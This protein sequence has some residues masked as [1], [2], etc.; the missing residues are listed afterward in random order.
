MAEV[1]DSLGRFIQGQNIANLTL[2]EIKGLLSEGL[3]KP[4]GAAKPVGKNQTVDPSIS[5]LTQIFEKFS[6]QFKQDVNDQKKYLENMIDVL[7]QNKT[8][9]EENLNDINQLC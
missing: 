7:K 5:K 1:A 9:K 6:S 3:S 4:V 2:N 8:K